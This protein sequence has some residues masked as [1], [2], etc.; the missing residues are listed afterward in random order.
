MKKILK[1]FI[2]PIL[3]LLITSAD[4][5]YSQ[6][7]LSNQ[8]NIIPRPESIEV[9]DGNIL[10]D[11]NLNVIID[12]KNP[13]LFP[14][15]KYFS[16]KV[17]RKLNGS[18]D[19]A[20]AVGDS[21]FGKEIIFELDS[22]LGYLGDEGY[23]L[24]ITENG[25]R[26]SAYQSNGLFHSIQTLRQLLPDDFESDSFIMADYIKLPFVSITDKPRFPWRG[27]LL[28]CCRHFMS[29]D[30]IKKYIDLL[31][32]YKMNRFH[33]HLTED[34]GWRIEIKKYPELTG[35]SAWRT[36][37]DDSSY[38][39]FY[40]QKEI[41]EIVKYASDRFITVIPEIEMPGHSRAALAAFPELSCTGDSLPVPNQ[42]GVF[43]DVY[44]AGNENVFSFLEN[45]LDEVVDLFP[46]EY[47][48]IG[49]DEVPKDR[50]EECV[51]CQK[52]ITDENLKDES[53][54]QSYF[55]NR[56][57]NY[58]TKKGKRIIGWDEILEGDITEDAIIQ[59]WRGFEGA[60]EAANTG[61]YSIV[62][63]TSHAY[64]DYDVATTD[65]RKVYSFDPVH[66]DIPKDKKKYILG[67]EC[68]MW[69]ERAPQELVDSKIFPRILAMSEV[70]WSL[71]E[72]KNYEQFYT[73]VHN[74][75]K[76]LKSMDVSYGP[77]AKLVKI[78]VSFNS[79][80]KHHKISIEA[81]EEG[82][83]LF[84]SLDEKTPGINSS[85]YRNPFE[86]FGTGI[87][88][89]AAYRDSVRYGEIE[90]LEIK[91]HIALGR[92]PAYT[93]IY[94]ER[95]DGG[96]DF[97]I[98]NGI[99]GSKNFRD[100]KWQGF[101]GGDFEIVLDFNEEIDIRKITIGTIQASSSW[102]FLPEYVAFSIS[103]DGNNFTEI[104]KLS[105]NFR[106]DNPETILHEFISVKRMRTR[107][108]KVFGKNIAVCPKWHPGAGGR[109]WVFID[110]VIVK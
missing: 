68:N 108:L 75:Y 93:N 61:R 39:G 77:E 99:R 84:Y 50:W 32:Y 60:L 94:N 40:T 17:L 95:Y 44:C 88:K 62:S 96:G 76:I 1:T 12:K 31:V 18:E 69:T 73:R 20:Q 109:A 70:L 87:I 5:L 63:P 16:E 54:L 38:G 22:T 11:A 36:T 83:D 24:D 105:H 92:K 79:R 82:L 4:N 29:V 45:V 52:R 26:S 35:I 85:K 46:S 90:T 47:I 80:N 42:W 89:A 51:K 23:K 101:E 64:F 81:G 21:N 19:K 33:W 102:I 28:D 41:K 86:L 107:F 65:L 57:N 49:G 43:K 13:K 6:D 78:H 10:I 59:S 9:K 7:K 34:Q 56:M 72:N 98:T 3:F 104:D 55:I 58:L 106:Q 91:N 15:E 67:G 8:I 100:G 48:H 25:I 66:G 103:D 71:P 110:E 14:I 74:H 97:G 2:V 37:E 53:E 30:F 27:L